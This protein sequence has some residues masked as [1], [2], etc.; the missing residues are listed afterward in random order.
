[1]NG[2]CKLNVNNIFHACTKRPVCAKYCDV[3]LINAFRWFLF[4]IIS[5][6]ARRGEEVVL[7]MLNLV[8]ILELEKPET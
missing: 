5:I 1:M 3:C 8:G 7:I 6:Q 2:R 4:V